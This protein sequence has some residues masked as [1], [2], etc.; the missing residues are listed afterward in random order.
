MQCGTEFGLRE[1]GFQP[2]AAPPPSA[3]LIQTAEQFVVVEYADWL[4]VIYSFGYLLLLV[5]VHI[6]TISVMC[7]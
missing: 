1:W 4:V 2:P 7:A 6:I 3:P 5:S